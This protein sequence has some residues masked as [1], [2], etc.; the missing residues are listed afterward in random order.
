MEGRRQFIEIVNRF[1][2]DVPWI[3]TFY[4][5][6]G[7]SSCLEVQL[8]RLVSIEQYWKDY[9]VSVVSCVVT[10]EGIK[11]PNCSFPIAFCHHCIV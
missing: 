5:T 6:D 4:L 11:E 8:Q 10:Q 1:D 2:V 7:Y 9:C 3:G